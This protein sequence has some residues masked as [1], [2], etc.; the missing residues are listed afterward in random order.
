MRVWLHVAEVPVPFFPRTAREA[1]L[2]HNPCVVRG[3]RLVRHPRVLQEQIL[4]KLDRSRITF[5]RR[6]FDRKSDIQ[7][8]QRCY[9]YV[10]LP[11]HKLLNELPVD[12]N[13]KIHVPSRVLAREMDGQATTERGSR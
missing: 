11:E 10:V 8:S 9:T 4:V 2:L 5:K 7:A 12:L 1:Y 13:E 6:P 3:R